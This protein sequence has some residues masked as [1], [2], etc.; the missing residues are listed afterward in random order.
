M[1][2]QIQRDKTG[3]MRQT[4]RIRNHTLTADQSVAG[5]GEDAG[6]DPHELYDAALGACKALTVLWYA[7]RKGLPVE[8]V[9]VEVERDGSQEQQGT[10]KLRASMTFVGDLTDADRERLLQVAAK[11][12]VHKLMTQVTTEIETVMAG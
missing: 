6:P 9:L 10:Y 3:P 5:G 12:P 2:I 4:V 7:Q 8:D 1:S 11:C